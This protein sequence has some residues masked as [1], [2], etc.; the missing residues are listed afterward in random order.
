MQGCLFLGQPQEPAISKKDLA[1]IDL[2]G[3]NHKGTNKMS[4]KEIEA[5]FEQNFGREATDPEIARFAEGINSK[6]D[7]NRDN[8]GYKT[9]RAGQEDDLKNK[10]SQSA[11]TLAEMET[12]LGE[13]G[14]LYSDDFA[15]MAQWIKNSSPDVKFSGLNITQLAEMAGFDTLSQAQKNFIRAEFLK[16]ANGLDAKVSSLRGKK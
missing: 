5:M 15:G 2:I 16:I 14:K 11:G 4:P 8:A 6:I 13:M 10:L 1:K 7:A 9:N 3:R 12:Q